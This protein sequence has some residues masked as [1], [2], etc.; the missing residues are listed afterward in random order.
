MP[1]QIKYWFIMSVFLH[2]KILPFMFSNLLLFRILLPLI[3]RPLHL[4][5]L[6]Y[7][8]LRGVV[9]VRDIEVYG[10]VETI[11]DLGNR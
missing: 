9:P 7:L 6:Y 5:L 4:N 8:K 2:L 11:L 3:K 10:G 1:N